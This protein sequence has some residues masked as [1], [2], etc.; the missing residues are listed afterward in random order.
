MILSHLHP[1]LLGSKQICSCVY[2]KIHSFTLSRWILK[3]FREYSWREFLDHCSESMHLEE[4]LCFREAKESERMFLIHT[5][6]E[7]MQSF[8]SLWNCFPPKVAKISDFFRQLKLRNF[9]NFCLFRFF[10]SNPYGL[11]DSGPTSDMAGWTTAGLQPTTG[12]YSP[13]DPTLA[14]YG[15]VIAANLST[16]ATRMPSRNN[17][18][19]TKHWIIA[20]KR[21]R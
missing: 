8:F 12:Y 18:H 20:R 17:L 21:R 14:A 19:C 7:N 10:Q 13:Y 5:A 9:I 4:C 16:T 15:W 3:E 6:K 1:P 11:K 2:S